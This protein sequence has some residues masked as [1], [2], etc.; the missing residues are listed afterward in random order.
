M[1]YLSMEA[2]NGNVRNILFLTPCH[3]TPYYS[4]LHRNLPM[5]FLDCT[6]R[7]GLLTCFKHSSHLLCY[8]YIIEHEPFLL[9]IISTV[10][11]KEC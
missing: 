2:V 8:V 11:R 7:S 3:A 5:R 1:N 6:P 10:K 4:T 9:A